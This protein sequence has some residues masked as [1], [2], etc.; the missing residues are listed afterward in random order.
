MSLS[1]L[2]PASFFLRLVSTRR[3]WSADF[4]VGDD[5]LGRSNV[6]PRCYVGSG[7]G[8]QQ[9]CR[10]DCTPIASQHPRRRQTAAIRTPAHAAASPREPR[11]C[12]HLSNLVPRIPF[13]SARGLAGWFATGRG[14]AGRHKALAIGGVVCRPE[15]RHAA[16]ARR[17]RQHRRR[18]PRPAVLGQHALCLPNRKPGH[19]FKGRL[20]QNSRVWRTASRTAGCQCRARQESSHAVHSSALAWSGSTSGRK[21]LGPSPSPTTPPAVCCPSSTESRSRRASG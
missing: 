8:T 1:I 19:I 15:Q 18:S 3:T 4:R 2:D 11:R 12:L 21:P 10:S 17:T 7:R 16:R 5:V 20:L 6:N 9:L 14:W 13:S